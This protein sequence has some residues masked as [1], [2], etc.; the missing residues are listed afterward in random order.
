MLRLDK[1]HPLVSGN[2]WFKLKHNLAAAQ[3]RENHQILS[4]GGGYSNHLIATAVAAQAEGLKAI[5]VVCGHYEEARMTPTLQHCVHAGMELVFLTKQEYA[6]AKVDASFAER[7]SDAFII[8][9]GGLNEEGIRGAGEMARFVPADITD[10]CVPIGSGTSFLGLR[11]ALPHSVRLHGFYVARDFEYAESLWVNQPEECRK[12]SCV[13]RV[14]DPRFGRWNRAAIDFIQD[15][16]AATNVP[17]D[18]VYTS[19]MMAAVEALLRSH[20]FAANAR[21]MCLHTG[22]LQ[23]NPPEL[24]PPFRPTSE[25]HF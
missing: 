13:H 12:S 14:E 22:G 25:S 23:G 16:F 18:V 20:F 5:G 10:V 7:F 4:F 24:P 21:I 6:H 17:L 15:F 2:K 8:P 11:R 3:S 1:L 19:K 9:E